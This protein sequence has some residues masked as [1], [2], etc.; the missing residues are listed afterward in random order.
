MSGVSGGKK[1]NSKLFLMA[2]SKL[3]YT[4]FYVLNSLIFTFCYL[5]PIFR[6]E[7]ILFIQFIRSL[8]YNDLKQESSKKLDKYAIGCNIF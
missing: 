2:S 3:N 8:F 5:S 6:Y 1:N 4:I 7:G